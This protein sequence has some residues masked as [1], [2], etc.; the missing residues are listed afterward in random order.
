[1]K[2]YSIRLH[3]IYLHIDLTYADKND[4]KLLLL[5]LE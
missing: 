2:T 1:M 3:K 4:N 5:V